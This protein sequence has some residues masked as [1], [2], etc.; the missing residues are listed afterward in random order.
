MINNEQRAHEIALH[1]AV[2]LVEIDFPDSNN[3]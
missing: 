2:K 1:A 3:Q